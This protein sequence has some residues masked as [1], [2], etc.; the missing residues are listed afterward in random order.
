MDVTT[1]PFNKLIG[2]AASDDPR[3]LLMLPTEEKYRNHIGTV[4]ASALFAL[5]EATSGMAMLRE[6]GGRTDLGALVRKVE[7]KYRNPTRGAVYSKA[8]L[9][10]DKLLLLLEIDQ[11]GRGFAHVTVDL[12]DGEAGG[13][14][15]AA[16]PVARF[17]FEWFVTKILK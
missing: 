12:F 11:R 2:L 10:E 15:A 17:E 4:H 5:A 3:Y 14:E 6:L 7:T 16:K 13:A 1:I 9:A 8:T